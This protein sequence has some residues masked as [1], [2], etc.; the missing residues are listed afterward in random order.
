MGGLTGLASAP[1]QVMLLSGR[2]SPAVLWHYV[3]R[4]RRMFVSENDHD[5]LT[6][7][8]IESEDET[9]TLVR[10]YAP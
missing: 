7:L 1:E 3:D 6:A 9:L 8:I 10:L 2:R 5:E 4:P